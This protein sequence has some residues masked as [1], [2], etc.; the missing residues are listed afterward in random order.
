MWFTQSGT[1]DL[2]RF[3]LSS[4]G[5]GRTHYT[6]CSDGECSGS[7]RGVCSRLGSPARLMTS[8]VRAQSRDGS[9]RNHVFAN[10]LAVM[11]ERAPPRRKR[12]KSLT[13]MSPV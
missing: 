8:L 4:H 11:A 9:L 13:C 5:P 12:G 10:M 3:E 2:V 7:G 1:F 6:A